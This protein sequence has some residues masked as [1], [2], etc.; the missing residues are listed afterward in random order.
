MGLSHYTIHVIAYATTTPWDWSQL[1]LNEP[2]THC[3]FSAL[4]LCPGRVNY[5]VNAASLCSSYWVPIIEG[6]MFVKEE[7]RSI[8]GSE[9]I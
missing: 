1:L 2:N 3:A 8:S 7:C 9:A 4:A 6:E 5:F